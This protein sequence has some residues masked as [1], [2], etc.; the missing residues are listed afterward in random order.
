VLH[1]RHSEMGAR[2]AV[3]VKE[4]PCRAPP[5]GIIL[6]AIPPL[7]Q[8]ALPGIM[9]HGGHYPVS[10]AVGQRATAAW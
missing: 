7:P 6:F 10:R 9:Q 8:R 1:F 2:L 5:L 4:E 3:Q